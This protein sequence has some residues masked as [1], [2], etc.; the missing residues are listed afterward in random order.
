MLHQIYNRPFAVWINFQ[1]QADTHSS[2]LLI[3]RCGCFT[4]LV[5]G[6][7]VLVNGVG[8]AFD[9]DLFL[10]YIFTKF[11]FLAEIYFTLSRLDKSDSMRYEYMIY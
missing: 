6:T 8:G 2:R 1:P 10:L 4:Y 9:K 7:L 3:F 11:G 5:V